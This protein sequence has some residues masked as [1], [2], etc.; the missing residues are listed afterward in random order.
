MKILTDKQQFAARGANIAL[1]KGMILVTSAGNDGN[2]FGTVGTPGDAPGIFTIGAVNSEGEYA[3]FS[4]RGPTVD[5]RVKPDVMTQ[6]ADAAV[7]AQNGNVVFNNGTS[8]SSPIL[9]GSITCLWQSRPEIKNFKIM[10]L[11][12]ESAHLYN[13]PY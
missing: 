12:R 13:N 10:R 1:E 2:G 5:G 11:V 8:F 3:S 9:A 7:V 4:S 6:G